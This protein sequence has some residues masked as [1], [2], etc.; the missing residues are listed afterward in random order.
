MYIYICIYF[1]NSIYIYT[2][3]IHIYIHCTC[4]YVCM[5][6]R[7]L[8]LDFLLESIFDLQKEPWLQGYIH[9]IHHPCIWNA[10]AEVFMKQKTDPYA[11]WDW[12]MYL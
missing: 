8:R 3:S 9:V 7:S 4:T 11:S 2:F 1:L 10:N 5:Y 12:N 6:I